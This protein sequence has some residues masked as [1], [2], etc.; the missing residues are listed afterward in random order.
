MSNPRERVYTGKE[1]V[2]VL[3]D[4]TEYPSEKV[5]PVGRSASHK[6]RSYITETTKNST[7]SPFV[8]KDILR[9]LIVSF[10]NMHYVDGENKLIRVKSVHGNPE[11]TIAKITQ[12]DNIVLPIITI[13][14]DGAKDD[15]QKRRYDNILI[16]RSEWSEDTQRAERV[17]GVADVPVK[18]SFNINLWAKYMEDLDQLSQGIRVMFNPS[19]LLKTPVSS[20]IK[21]FLVSE[22]NK[23]SV[24]TGD[25]E[26]RVLRKSY[27]VDVE[28]YIPSPKFKVTSTGRIE[29]VV[30]ELWIS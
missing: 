8:Y 14:Q 18:L 21:A 9:A 5:F 24:V 28:A 7:L 17:I 19:I 13:H 3:S 2:D 25:R 15:I 4:T 30:N 26:D 16:Q 22:T 12:E 29:K 20:S 27:A 1:I 6:F 11:R 10:G 23:S